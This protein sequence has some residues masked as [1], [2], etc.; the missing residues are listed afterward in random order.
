MD[1]KIMYGHHLSADSYWDKLTPY[2]VIKETDKQVEINLPNGGTSKV[3]KAGKLFDSM[4]EAV[5]YVR[6][7]IQE[8]I[9]T[10]QSRLNYEKQEMEKFK[11]LYNL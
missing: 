7:K 3:V 10:H 6:K 1:K 8:K 4:E 5:E 2:E 11:K 9:D